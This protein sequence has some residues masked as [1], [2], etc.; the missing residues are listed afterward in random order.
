M[1]RVKCETK[2][3]DKKEIKK[4]SRMVAARSTMS[5][6]PS[7]AD[8][9]HLANDYRLVPV[10]RRIVSDILTPVTAFHQLHGRSSGFLFESVV[11]GDVVG[12]YSFLTTEPRLQFSAVARQVEIRHGTTV[13][14]FEAE[15]P[16]FVLRDRLALQRVAPVEGLP[17]FVGG[18]VGYLGYDA[19]RYWEDLPHA[20]LDDRHLPDISMA[21]YDQMVVFD[22]VRKTMDI[23]VLAQVGVDKTPLQAYAAACERVDRLVDRLFGSVSLLPVVEWNQPTDEVGPYT[24][25][26]SQDQYEEAVRKCVDYIRAGDIFQ[27]VLSQRLSLP[28]VA[29][30]FEVYRTLRTINPSPFMF[31]LE[32]PDTVLVGS[33]P[34]I[35]CR[36]MDR[37]VVVRPLAGTRRRGAT[38]EEDQRLAE[39]LLADPKERAEHVMLVDLGRNDVGRVAKYG[40]LKLT[41]VMGVER[42]SHVMHL[43][44]NVEGILR[45]DLDA[46]DALMACLP[47]GTVSGAPKV[48]AMQI[49]DEL[50]PHRR[51]PY[52]GAIGYFDFRGNMDTCIALRTIVMQKGLAYVQAGAGIV[53]DS[54]PELEYQETLNKARVL[55]R[56]LA[57]TDRR[58]QAK[59]WR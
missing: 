5:H 18:A 23:V 25:N 36:V 53:A 2:R 48:R 44:S 38:R 30:P 43:T 6:F 11:G 12:R 28:V 3:H 58:F 42:Y 29:P 21:L 57:E 31:Y 32:T 14:R 8:F 50:E 10:Y 13:E 15:N 47:A 33:S 17:P 7:Y 56:A 4:A 54:V 26:M 46:F 37:K 49:I 16:L 55:L 19:V 59:T 20:P 24:S 22:N 45:D 41:D 9:Q 1:G 40:S 39:E 27:V 51:G 52:A 34:E 35:M